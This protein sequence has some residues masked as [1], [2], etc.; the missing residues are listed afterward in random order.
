MTDSDLQPIPP[1]ELETA[2]AKPLKPI[3]RPT[4][5]ALLMAIVAGLLAPIWTVRFPLLVDYPN[6]LASAYVLAH[7]Q[8]SAFHFSQYYRANWNTY[9]YLSMDVILLGLQHFVPIEL[10]GRLFLSLCVLS[11]PVAAWFFLR[12]ANPGNESLALWSLLICH[13]MYFFRYGFLNLQL[14]MAIC[15]FLLGLWLWHLERPRVVTWLLLLL[16]ATAL[17]FTHLVGFAVA[18]IVMTAY[19]WAMRRGWKEM[20]S[21]WAL[22][23]PGGVCYLH[24]VV[25]HTQR[26][27]HEYHGL[28]AKIGGL[29]SVM[30]GSS[31]IIDL[32]TIIVL[33]G[34]LAWAQIDNYEFQVNRPWRRAAL[35]LFLFYW[36][37]PAVI[38]PATNVDKRILPFVFVLSLA[39]AQV[40]SR[41]RKIAMVAV[42]LFFLRAGTLERSFVIPQRHFAKLAEVITSIPR[43]ARVLPLVDW[44][45]G[46]SWPERHFWAYGVIW[47]RWVTP[48]LFHDPGVHPFALKDDP[49]DPCQVSLTPETSLD[50]SRIGNEFDYVWVYHLPQYAQHLSSA[51]K[52]I[53]S[54]EDLQV[55]RMGSSPAVVNVDRPMPTP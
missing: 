38:G 25:G 20:I 53:F 17:Y 3:S 39:T 9:P 55:F 29:I 37:L 10:A 32:L 15:L 26:G 33:L 43:G 49:Y 24:A 18:A 23:L 40:G 54:G 51:G 8:D 21:T 31:P 19:A 50:W 16:V 34:V 45:G 11:V 27:G 28:A 1:G 42:L 7:L 6:H 14:S 30:V 2:G 35:I 44:A 13:N 22:Y 52:M 5:L 48:C 47:Q 41:G 46:A 4:M 36:I 12:R